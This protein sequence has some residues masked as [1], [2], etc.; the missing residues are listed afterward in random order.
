M[1]SK[2]NKCS[3]CT[4]NKKCLWHKKSFLGFNL[5][6]IIVTVAVIAVIAGTILYNEDPEKRIG[7][8]RDAQRIQELDAITKAI[9]SYALEYHALPGD[10]SLASLRNG[11]K[12]VLSIAAA[13]LTC[14]GQV[15][16]C[17]VID[18]VNFLGKHLPVLPVDP[19]KSGTTDTGYYITRAENNFGL[20]VGACQTYDTTKEM[21]KVANASLPVYVA[22]APPV[23]C[24]NGVLD[25]GELCDYTTAATC[26]YNL[27]YYTSG[28]V[29]DPAQCAEPDGCSSSCNSCLTSCSEY[30]KN[31]PGSPC[32]PGEEGC[33]PSYE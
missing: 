13:K 22:E 16:D 4:M 19:E 8:A 29:Y 21:V 27:D 20:K 32:D 31:P 3:N 15:K 10:L 7:K 17:V 24:G 14:D 9:A 2:N 25:A 28:I 23:G 1:F 5:I 12:R 11:E 6:Q 26:Q 30:Y 33:S 18:D